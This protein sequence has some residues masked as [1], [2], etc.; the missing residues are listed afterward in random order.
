MNQLEA[1]RKDARRYRML[2]TLICGPEARQEE[3]AALIA[4][5]LGEGDPT[6]QAMDRAMDLALNTLKLV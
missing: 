3:V 2:R 5:L 6:P 4:P 1:D